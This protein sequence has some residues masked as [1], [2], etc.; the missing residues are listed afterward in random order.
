MDMLLGSTVGQQ[1]HYHVVLGRAL[2]HGTTQNY[3]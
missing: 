3:D 1:L 2:L